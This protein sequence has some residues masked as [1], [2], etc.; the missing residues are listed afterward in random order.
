MIGETV[1]AIACNLLSVAKLIYFL[2]RKYTKDDF[3]FPEK[4]NFVSLLHNV[5]K[6]YLLFNSL[7]F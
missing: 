1:N 6:N 3:L 7:E 4:S 5:F 2:S